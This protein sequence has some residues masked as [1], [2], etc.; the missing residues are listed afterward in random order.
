MSYLISHLFDNPDTATVYIQL[1]FSLGLFTGPIV[2]A[3][4]CSPIF[5][6]SQSVTPWYLVNPVITFIVQLYTICNTGKNAIETMGDV[7]VL[8]MDTPP[9][10]SMFAGLI[11]AQTL[12]KIS[13]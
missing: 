10:T 2:I 8:G 7:K 3:S 5:G 13:P 12:I 4:I 11:I 1:I 9:S 6:F